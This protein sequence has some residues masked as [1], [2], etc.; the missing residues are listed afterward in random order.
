M[1]FGQKQMGG[2]R[3]GKQ[4]RLAQLQLARD[5]KKSQGEPVA[6]TSSS[7][8]TMP[9]RMAGGVSSITD[10]LYIADAD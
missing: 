5:L 3:G 4:Q 1:P 6:T 10:V 7:A 9:T 8:T 2:Y